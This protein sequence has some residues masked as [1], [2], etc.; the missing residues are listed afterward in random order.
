[1]LLEAL[2]SHISIG[3]HITVRQI[4]Y[5]KCFKKKQEYGIAMEG[6]MH[7]I[8]GNCRRKYLTLHGLEVC[9]TMW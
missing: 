7:S 6:Q 3:A 1:M 5:L 9:T 2:L 8:D 4:F